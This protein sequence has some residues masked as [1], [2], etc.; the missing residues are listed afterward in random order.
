[1][2][3]IF[4]SVP[5][6]ILLISSCTNPTDQKIEEQNDTLNHEE[7]H[8]QEVQ[9]IELNNG[10]K[11]KV[12]DSMMV[13]IRN[14]EKDINE[15]AA[16]DIKDYKSISKKLKANIDLLTSGCTMTGKAHDE[17]HKWLLP[18]IDIVN[19]LA[20]TKDEKEAAVQFK[21]IQTSFI[22]FNRYF[23]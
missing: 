20:E 2:K 9:A 4:I 16:S 11:W 19:E 18:Y 13:Y 12:D 21:K 8:H 1:M 6:S 3:H 17:L 7:H 10:Q 5:L 14:M 15:F 22:T 23:E